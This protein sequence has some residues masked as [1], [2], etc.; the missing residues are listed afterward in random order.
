MQRRSKPYFEFS[1][2]FL[3]ACPSLRSMPNTSSSV[4]KVGADIVVK[5]GDV[6]FIEAANMNF[7]RENTSIPVPKVL[8][9]YERTGKRYIVMEFVDGVLLE[10]VWRKCPDQEWGVIVSELKGYLGEMRAIEPPENCMIGSVLGGPAV[11][12]R[13]LGAVRAGPFKTETEFNDW[14]LFC[15]IPNLP[16]SRMEM[17]EGIFNS[18]QHKLVFSHGDLAYYNIMVKD[19]HIAAI[20]DWEFAGWYP[21]HWDYCKTLHSLVGHE[22]GYLFCKEIFEKQ[23]HMEYLVDQWFTRDVRHGC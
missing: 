10:D 1:D 20:I 6:E 7:I 21:E 3:A 16:L 23:Y 13:Q 19:G 14:Q 12:R 2:D 9:T 22:T 4:V 15:L 8:H 17:Y 18:L 11:D 5:Y